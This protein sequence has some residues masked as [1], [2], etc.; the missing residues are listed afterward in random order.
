MPRKAPDQVIEHRISLSNFEREKI[1]E[2]LTRQRENRL[3]A[4]GI[5]QIGA[6]AGSG[7]LLYALGLYFGIDLY[8]DLKD[9]VQDWID[10]TSDDLADL[11]TGGNLPF[12]GDEAAAI[13]SAFD[14]LDEAI[15]YH[16]TAERANSAAA[17]G[18]ITR[19]KNGDIS[20]DEFRV[21]IDQ[22]S[23]EAAELDQLRAD[24]VTVRTTVKRL[25]SLKAAGII[26]ALPAWLAIENWRD[27]ITAGLADETYTPG[28]SQ[29]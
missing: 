11:L 9:G 21:T 18:A 23:D 10:K 16:R 7:A 14:R 26:Q 17:Q 27:L 1:I 6:I 25:R 8:K 15:R 22:L 3:Y 2:E 19:L 13:I 24:I 29:S 28:T 20:M 5:N 4:A 12:S